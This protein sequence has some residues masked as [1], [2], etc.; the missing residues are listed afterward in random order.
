MTTIYVSAAYKS[1]NPAV[2]LAPNETGYGMR[3]MTL[4]LVAALTPCVLAL[5]ACV[6]RNQV[7]IASTLNEDDDSFCRAGGKVAPGSSEYVACRRD[8]DVQRNAAIVSADKKQRDL[9]EYMLNNP[10]R[11]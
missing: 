5:S 10:V 4:A 8:R 7:P 2:Q 1:H 9:A 11:P 3:V 6:Q